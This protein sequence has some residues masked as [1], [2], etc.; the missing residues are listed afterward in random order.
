MD[1]EAAETFP[2]QF[3][4]LI[5]EKRYVPE[6]VFNADE[7]ACSGKT[8]ALENFHLKVREDSIGVQHCKGPDISSPLHQ[9]QMGL[10]DQTDDAVP[11]WKPTCS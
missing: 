9:R 3:A 11:F 10:H 6:Q 2:A 8:N 1:Q 7:T 4:Q 5:E